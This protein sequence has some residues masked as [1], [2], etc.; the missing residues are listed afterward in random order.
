MSCVSL[1][2]HSRW[3]GEKG[4]RRVEQTEGMEEG[5]MMKDKEIE[6]WNKNKGE[7]NGAG[8]GIGYE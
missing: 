2:H 8:Y 5:L 7:R 1:P 3:K 4:R 6:A